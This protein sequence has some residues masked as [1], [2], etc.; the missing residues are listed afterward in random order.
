ME[1]D[2]NKSVFKGFWGNTFSFNWRFGLF[3]IVALG[4][5]RF[6]VVLNSNVTGRYNYVSII[7]LVMWVLPFIFLSKEGRKH[8]GFTRVKHISWLFHSFFIGGLSCLFVFVLG[9]FMYHSTYQNWFVYL[10]R[11]FEMYGELVSSERFVLFAVSSI[12]AMTFSPIGEEIFYRGLVH[13]S[14]VAEFGERKASYIDSLAFAFTHLAHFGIVFI[15]GE[16][17]LLILPSIL[18]VVLMFFTSRL[19]FYCKKKSGSLLGPILSHAAFNLVMMYII[20]YLII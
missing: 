14:F 6:I 4:V 16:W 1:T 2:L 11:P 19:F 12:F 18:W 15:N 5:P 8:I 17:Q 20:F 10:A 3:L 9:Y 13:G 7:F